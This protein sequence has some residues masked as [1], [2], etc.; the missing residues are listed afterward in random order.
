MLIFERHVVLAPSP[1]NLPAL[2]Y[3][4]TVVLSFI[5]SDLPWLPQV[6]A[7]AS[8]FSQVG[9]MLMLVLPVGVLLL[10]GNLFRAEKWLRLMVW[11]FLALGA[12]Y[13]AG[14]L[15]FG[16]GLLGNI[17]N[18]KSVSALFY[19]WMVAVSG[20]MLLFN[21][22]LNRRWRWVMGGLLA[23][24]MLTGM[25][26]M[27]SSASSW[28]PAL[29]TLGVLL[30]LKWWRL[31]LLVGFSGGAW[32]VLRFQLVY[33]T[34]LRT[35]E[36]S[37]VTRAATWPIMYQL[38]KA[39]PLLGLGPSNYYFYTAHYSLLGYYV[40]FN[41]HNNYWDLA[42]QVGLLGLG[43]FL[44]LAAGLGRTAWK[45]RGR[46]LNGF[47]RGYANACLAGLLGTLAAGMLADWFM[48]FVYNIG[49]DGFRGA[50]FAWLFLGGVIALERLNVE[51]LK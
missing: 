41:S 43:L 2:L 46:S 19:V 23:A 24:T 51:T 18:D 17:Y 22:D 20:G 30:A 47:Q 11:L 50:I 39:S 32:L 35:E 29:L 48:P 10:V 33:E 40:Q 12:P 31:G 27:R 21:Q 16:G 49:F 5:A 7:R 25:G 44:W 3:T 13:L 4:V 26:P 6:S 38:V 42:A 1:I 36:Y 34:L 15:I 37:A 8:T 9:G 14:Q 45:L 28:A